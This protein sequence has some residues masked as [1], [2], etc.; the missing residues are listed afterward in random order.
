[1]NISINIQTQIQLSAYF[2]CSIAK[3]LKATGNIGI[4]D[5]FGVQDLGAAYV[6]ELADSTFANGFE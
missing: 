5:Q 2:N 4:D 1:M 6:S 3:T